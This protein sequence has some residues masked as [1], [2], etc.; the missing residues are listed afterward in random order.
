MNMHIT[1]MHIK[2]FIT[3]EFEAVKVAM[4]VEHAHNFLYRRLW[5]IFSIKIVILL[6]ITCSNEA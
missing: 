4:Q 5:G 3:T 1:G 2:Y 6:V